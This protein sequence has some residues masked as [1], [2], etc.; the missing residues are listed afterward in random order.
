MSTTVPSARDVS[1]QSEGGIYT[2]HDATASTAGLA[3][4]EDE[5]D[6]IVVAFDT[7]THR[8]FRVQWVGFAGQDT[9]EPERSL[10]QQGC[11][12]SIK[13]FWLAAEQPKPQRRLH[14]RSTVMALLQMR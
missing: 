3:E 9:W 6:R 7:P 13:D 4:K 2:V 8:W 5:V 1:K 10:Q 14:P 11:S 12:D